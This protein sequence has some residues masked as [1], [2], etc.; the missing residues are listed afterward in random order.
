MQVILHTLERA[1]KKQTAISKQAVILLEKAL[2]DPRFE[3][4]FLKKR[5]SDLYFDDGS[6]RWKQIT[7]E[8]ALSKLLSGSELNLSLIHI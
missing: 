8:E 5:F 6:D 7:K 3:T 4:E 1:G 2:N